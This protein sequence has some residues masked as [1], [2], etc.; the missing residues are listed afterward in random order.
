MTQAR[1]HGAARHE[2]LESI[3]YDE[4]IETGLGERFRQSVQA[5]VELAASL[6]FMGSTHRQGTNPPRYRH[7]AR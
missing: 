6:P 1:F 4:K 7:V 5:A 3:T 2:F